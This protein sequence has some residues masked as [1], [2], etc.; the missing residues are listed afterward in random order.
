VKYTVTFTVH[1]HGFGDVDIEETVGAILSII[2]VAS[3]VSE[4][5]L[6]ALSTA[7][8]F[9]R[10]V[11]FI[12]GVVQEYVPSFA[13]LL[14]IVVQSIPPLVEYDKVIGF[15]ARLVSLI[16]QLFHVIS[17]TL[18]HVRYVPQFGEVNVSLGTVGF[19]ISRFT[20]FVDIA[21]AFLST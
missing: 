8:I 14:A 17:C 20:L 18:H 11:E 19:V 21:T 2:N 16:D 13:S 3:L 10:N 5:V 12:S 1:D 7:V 15:V 6:L 9:T 4:E